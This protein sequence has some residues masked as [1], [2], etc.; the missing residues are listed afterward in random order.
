MNWCQVFPVGHKAIP[1]LLCGPVDVEEKIDGRPISFTAAATTF[2]VETD[3]PALQYLE[4]IRTQLKPEYTYH[5]EVVEQLE[6]PRGI[7]Y[8]R[9]PQNYIMLLDVQDETGQ[10]LPHE[11]KFC[12]ADRLGLE[13]VPLLFQGRILDPQQ[14]L[15]LLEQGST[16]G[17]PIEGV[18]LKPALSMLDRKKRPIFG[19]LESLQISILQQM[20]RSRDAYMEQYLGK[21]DAL[22][23]APRAQQMSAAGPDGHP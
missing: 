11:E 7:P 4:Q 22:V 10:L 13:C 20:R 1:Q 19:K 5:G 17:G 9:T 2:D 16:L 12:E 18:V 14:L 23:N 15:D 8:T 6:E 3:S 21:F